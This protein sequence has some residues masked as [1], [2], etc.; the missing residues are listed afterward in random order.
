MPVLL[1]EFKIARQ[2]GCEQTI[3]WSL[4]YRMIVLSKVL[5]MTR[6]AHC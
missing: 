3:A 2:L 6:F 1:F 4:C 5:I